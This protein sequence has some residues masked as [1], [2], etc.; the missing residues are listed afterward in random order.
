MGMFDFAEVGFNTDNGFLEGLA[1]GFKNGVLMKKHYKHMT[2]CA[3]LEGLLLFLLKLS[4]FCKQSHNFF[5][6]IFAFIKKD[7]GKS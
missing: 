7:K 3:S 6:T 2:Q 1:R 5:K 4:W